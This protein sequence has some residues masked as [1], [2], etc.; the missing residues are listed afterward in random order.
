MTAIAPISD[1][2]A[3]ATGYQAGLDHP[4]PYPAGRASDLFYE[5]FADAMGA[6]DAHRSNR[7][8]NE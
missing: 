1:T 2:E 7:E 5:G 6:A 3:Y 4:C 8:A